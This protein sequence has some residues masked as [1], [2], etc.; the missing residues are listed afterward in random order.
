MYRPKLLFSRK[1]CFKMALKINWSVKTPRYWSIGIEVARSCFYV[2]RRKRTLFFCKTF[3]SF[4]NGI[5][6]IIPACIVSFAVW[7]FFLSTQYHFSIQCCEDSKTSVG[8]PVVYR[9]MGLRGSTPRS[10]EMP[11]GTGEYS[12]EMAD[13][14]GWWNSDLY[15]VR[16]QFLH[17]WHPRA[18]Q[19]LR[20]IIQCDGWTS[21][22]S[23]VPPASNS[24]SV[25][26][27]FATNIFRRCYID[28]S[29]HPLDLIKIRFQGKMGTTN[30]L[31]VCNVQMYCNVKCNA[32]C[33]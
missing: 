4:L 18:L 3:V 5:L 17:I 21:G 25:T 10:A 20:T 33:N 26:C 32:I 31:V 1:Q 15:V 29:L 24:P 22:Y 23:W 30:N 11:K 13:G 2:S 14:V 27:L 9:G 12:L 8:C 28:S 19:R 6:P 16:L 7:F